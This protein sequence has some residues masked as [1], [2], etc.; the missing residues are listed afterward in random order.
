MPPNSMRAA[1]RA[2]SADKPS[3][4]FSSAKVSTYECTSSS[5]SPS[6]RRSMKIFRKKLFIRESMGMWC[7]PYSANFASFVPQCDHGIHASGAPRW[8]VT[9]C[10]RDA[11]E[12][13]SSTDEDERVSGADAE[14]I[15]L[16]ESSEPEGGGHSDC[17]ASEDDKEAFPQHE[18][19]HAAQSCSEGHP[20]S[21]F[22]CASRRLVTEHPVDANGGENEREGSKNPH[23]G[24]QE[25]LFSDRAGPDII[26][27]VDMS[28]G[29]FRVNRG[30]SLSNF[31][32][33]VHGPGG[34]HEQGRSEPEIRH[35][36]H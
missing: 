32:A 11:Y 30:D 35:L 33:D 23:E 36:V 9:G 4:I 5:S 10:E 31:V 21:D 24:H 27:G 26:H 1:R 12:H 17:H 18:A 14:Q 20:Y 19:R 28:D 7:P 2:C 13:N 6:F 34:A 25:A 29:F 15:A 16:E 22:V 3:R 8:D